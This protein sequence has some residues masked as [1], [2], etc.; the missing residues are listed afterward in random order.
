MGSVYILPK[1]TL[2]MFEGVLSNPKKSPYLPTYL[3]TYFFS[4]QKQR[5][6][7]ET[8]NI[9]QQNKINEFRCSV[10]RRAVW[11]SVKD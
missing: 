6:H 3:P 5:S 2:P 7:F 4:F 9:Y 1:D 8:A 11:Y 10:G